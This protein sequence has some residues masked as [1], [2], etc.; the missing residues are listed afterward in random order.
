MDRRVLAISRIATVA[1][2]VICTLMA[3]L[4]MDRNV[5]LI[6]WIGTGGMMA[7]FAGPLVVGAIWRGVTRAGALAGLIGGAAVFSIT[8]GA[9]IDPDWFA[10]GALR[11]A[12]LWLEREAGN[13]WSCAT[14][15]E[16]VSVAL[17]WGV[18]KLTRPLPGAHIERL[19]GAPAEAGGAS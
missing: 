3:W 10:P 13:P 14:M 18:S 19:F 9:F 17:T 8:H 1:V 15:G 7:A 6:V 5:A 2:M 16:I 11:Q 4:L 12:A